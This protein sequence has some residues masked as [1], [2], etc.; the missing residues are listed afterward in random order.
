MKFRADHTK[1]I[2]VEDYSISNS[3]PMATLGRPSYFL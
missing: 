1:Q 3:I 2:A